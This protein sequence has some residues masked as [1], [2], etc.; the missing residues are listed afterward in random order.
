MQ[1]YCGLGLGTGSDLSSRG[2]AGFME[3]MS[4]I[5]ERSSSSGSTGLCG[6][7]GI[8]DDRNISPKSV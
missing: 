7:D 3:A 5:G 6:Y 4:T 1:R 8:S 2:Q